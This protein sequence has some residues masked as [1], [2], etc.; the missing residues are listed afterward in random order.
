[1]ASDDEYMCYAREYV[2]LAVLTDLLPVK[3][4]LIEQARGWVGA[5]LRERRSDARTHHLRL[6]P[7]TPGHNS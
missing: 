2:R 6:I 1:M 5:A 4:Q 3:D 7:P